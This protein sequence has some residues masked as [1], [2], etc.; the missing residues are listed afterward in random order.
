MQLILL[1]SMLLNGSGSASMQEVSP[2]PHIAA[3]RFLA[4]SVNSTVNYT[5][6][7]FT[8]PTLSLPRELFSAPVPLFQD[9]PHNRQSWSSLRTPGM[10]FEHV[11]VCVAGG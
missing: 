5:P 1:Y 9:D 7:C 8:V 6:A 10:A 3:N 11:R 4:C 2:G